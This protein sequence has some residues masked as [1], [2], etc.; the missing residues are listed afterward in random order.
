MNDT[1]ENQSLYLLIYQNQTLLIL[2]SASI[3][4]NWIAFGFNLLIIVVILNN[5]SAIWNR[6]Y[7]FVLFQCACEALGCC[8]V[9][10]F[11]ILRLWAINREETD[12]MILPGLSCLGLVGLSYVSEV[13]FSNML[14]MFA[15]EQFRM[16]FSPMSYN[17]MAMKSAY[18]FAVLNACLPALFIVLP[19]IIDQSKDSTS[20]LCLS[21]YSAVFEFQ[22]KTILVYTFCVN[23]LA[24]MVNVCSILYNKKKLFTPR[25]N[26][27]ARSPV[28][29]SLSKEAFVEYM[30]TLVWIETF[31]GMPYS[32]L[33]LITLLC[34]L[35]DSSFMHILGVALAADGLHRMVA[36]LLLLIKNKHVRAY[37]I[38]MFKKN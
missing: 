12:Q 32:I 30:K 24:I 34:E 23:S 3:L 15:L 22:A 7:F 27:L 21:Y 37:T 18:W 16:Q 5:I 35:K 36:P 4:L 9:G 2:N 13:A 1:L 26:P 19:L 29:A 8:Q 14:L 20:I 38:A 10:I 28:Q 25:V 33:R 6:F 11:Q 31:I 17:L